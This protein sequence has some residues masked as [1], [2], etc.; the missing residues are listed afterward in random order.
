MTL[1][2]ENAIEIEPPDSLYVCVLRRESERGWPAFGDWRAPIRR[3]LPLC[4][5]API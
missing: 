2:I 4:S 3:P 1:Q 5:S